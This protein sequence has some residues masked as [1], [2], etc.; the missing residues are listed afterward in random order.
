MELLA[1]GLKSNDAIAMPTLWLPAG[2]AARTLP[3]LSRLA[4]R[5]GAVE[6]W[7]QEGPP[8]LCRRTGPGTYVCQ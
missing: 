4:R 5:I 7:E 6:V 3:S 1:R 2:R 8:D